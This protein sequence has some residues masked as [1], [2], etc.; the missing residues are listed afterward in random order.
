M[1]AKPAED[2]ARA[3]DATDFYVWKVP[4]AAIQ[5][6]IGLD[7]IRRIREYLTDSVRRTSEAGG[8]FI[9][10]PRARG[11]EIV[12][13]VRIPREIQSAPEFILSDVEKGALRVQIEE[14]NR[15]RPEGT[16]VGYFRSDIRK[17][18]CL[19]EE[20][21]KLI[22]DCFS[23][24][25]NV[26]LVVQCRD[27]DPATAGFFFSDDGIIF[28]SCS[29]MEFD[30]DETTLANQAY[31]WPVEVPRESNASGDEKPALGAVASS[32]SG[33][34][35]VDDRAVS[36]PHI[37]RR[38]A[39]PAVIGVAAMCG[40]GYLYQNFGQIRSKALPAEATRTRAGTSTKLGLSVA[41]SGSEI[42]ITWDAKSPLVTSARVALLTIQDGNERRDLPL[43]KDQLL[44]SKLVYSRNTDT[45][46]F[47]LEAYGEDGSVARENVIAMG[48]NANK[49]ATTHYETT[50]SAPVSTHPTSEEK[51]R[52]PAREFVAPSQRVASPQM[53][54]PAPP[55]V[56]APAELTA[57]L[58]LRQTPPTSQVPAAVPAAVPPPP[59]A[60]SPSQFATRPSQP[61]QVVPQTQ[62]RPPV[63]LRQVRP[64][65][66]DNVKSMLT[67][68]ASVKVRIQVDA[69]G[70]VTGA[71]PLTT[72]GSLDRVL[73][74]AAAGAAK[75]WVFEPAREGDRRVPSELT[76]EF[77]FVPEKQ[78]Q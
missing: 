60:S 57:R 49:P 41:T 46:H 55:P 44:S 17:G 59:Q 38:W 32:S 78:K 58:D 11:P 24:P 4:G 13:F 6:R 12:D 56:G 7:V 5:I 72:G 23:D 10:N 30:L 70:R 75:M 66:P 26:F 19:Y 53:D 48:N 54:N 74:S 47:A 67:S 36:P 16:V 77:T 9:G 62:Q 1:S 3:A 27:T 18:I 22:A 45:V 39:V 68:R 28:S 35:A 33:L 2:T 43:T 42:N 50:V 15:T 71:E 31:S 61:I 69:S 8:L 65:L 40:A 14:L 34:F 76:V 64:V 25:S 63:P 52:A 21:Q 37:V 20:D 29:F 73:S 51:K